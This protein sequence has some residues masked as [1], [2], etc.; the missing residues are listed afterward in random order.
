M[1][2]YFQKYIKYKN[3]YNILKGGNWSKRTNFFLL[4]YNDKTY[5]TGNIKKD[6]S[7]YKFINSMMFNNYTIDIYEDKKK[8]VNYDDNEYILFCKNSDKKIDIEVKLNLVDKSFIITMK[9]PDTSINISLEGNFE[10]DL[11][12][13][14]NFRFK[15]NNSNIIINNSKYPFIIHNNEYA[16]RE[17]FNNNI[18]KIDDTKGKKL[19]ELFD[20][21]QFTIPNI[22][23]DESNKIYKDLTLHKVAITPDCK[24]LAYN[25]DKKIFLYYDSSS[26][27]TIDGKKYF[28]EKNKDYEIS[29]LYD[30]DYTVYVD[31]N[32]K[33]ITKIIHKN[34]TIN[35]SFTYTNQNFKI[36]KLDNLIINNIE[37]TLSDFIPCKL[38]DFF[39]NKYSIKEIISCDPYLHNILTFLNKEDPKLNE[40]KDVTFDQISSSVY[41]YENEYDKFRDDNMNTICQGQNILFKSIYNSLFNLFYIENH[42]E[43]NK[44]RNINVLITTHYI[45]KKLLIKFQSIKCDLHKICNT[46]EDKDFLL[47]NITKKIITTNKDFEI[48]SNN[49]KDFIEFPDD[50][51]LVFDTGNAAETIIGRKVVQRL[52]L[53]EK[54]IFIT[55]GSG[56]GGVSEYDGKYVT[57][58]LKFKS[59]SPFNI[60]DKVYEFN[61]IVTSENIPDI[62]LIGQSSKGLKKFFEDNY[63]I[64]YNNSKTR[65]N[66]EYEEKLKN[67]ND[68][69]KTAKMVS[70]DEQIKDFINKIT[71]DV[72]NQYVQAFLDND[73]IVI[74]FN[75]LKN[76][77]FKTFIN[78]YLSSI[79]TNQPACIDNIK[80]IINNNSLIKSI[81][82]T[83]DWN[84]IISE[85]NKYISTNNIDPKIIEGIK[86]LK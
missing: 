14:Q 81:L 49:I 29:Y 63:C 43:I 42:D 61:A 25:E 66:E 40:L 51:R 44:L 86:K 22:F 35:G 13:F 84:V 80:F 59:I 11:V 75:E 3:K 65:Y 46:P 79:K 76:D 38:T 74:L 21:K 47:Q 34:C 5:K 41:D 55:K 10:Y 68:D 73:R 4:K 83:K 53:E 9:K 85:L 19:D 60:K 54:D 69:I 23:Y 39:K 70:T 36:D 18:V 1:D 77:K 67:I 17:I 64:V 52:G 8:I 62:L 33:I 58:K 28:F 48:F 50:L 37:I 7:G 32:S 57:V 71:E 26:L 31:N 78:K 6:D 15:I 45:R 20:F 30:L 12:K 2:N 72:I 82:D 27:K 16:L 56:V 24:I